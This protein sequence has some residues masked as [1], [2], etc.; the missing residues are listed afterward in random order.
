MKWPL[1]IGPIGRSETSIRNYHYK[2]HNILGE[3]RSHDPEYRCASLN[4]TAKNQRIRFIYLSLSVAL[5]QARN[6]QNLIHSLSA[7]WQ[8]T[9]RSSCY[10]LYTHQSNITY[11]EYP[12]YA[13]RRDWIYNLHRASYLDSCKCIFHK[14]I[15]VP[16]FGDHTTLENKI[17][18]L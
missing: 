13:V 12:H 17:E 5:P 9:K 11:R 10:Q 7:L 18:H 3:R 16:S 15:L 4:C 1:R 2:L 8:P 6:W 14:F